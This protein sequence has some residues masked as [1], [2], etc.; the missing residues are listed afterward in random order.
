MQND[1]SL[2]RDNISQPRI[3]ASQSLPAVLL[4]V[5]LA[6]SSCTEQRKYPPA[7]KSG[8]AVILDI[9]QLKPET[10]DFHTY[11]VEG[12]NINYFILSSQGKISAYLDAC[13]SCYT[14]K[15]GYRYDDGAVTCRY[16]SMKFPVSKLE[17]GIGGCY[18]IKI[19]GREENGKYS[20]PISTLEHAADKF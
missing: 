15:Q 16:C 3:S 5:M 1:S 14:H 7:M 12:K 13:A 11:H 18:P 19:E 8:P 6:L 2:H 10:P 17:K 20:I 4:L 9:A